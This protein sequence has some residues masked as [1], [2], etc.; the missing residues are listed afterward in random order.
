MVDNVRGTIEVI[1]GVTESD[2][3]E[4]ADYIFRRVDGNHPEVE[5]SS[6]EIT[7]ILNDGGPLADKSPAFMQRGLI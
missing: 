5:N 3:D 4:M 1:P 6:D 7:R 2:L